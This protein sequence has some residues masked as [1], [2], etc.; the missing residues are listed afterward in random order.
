MSM[1]TPNSFYLGWMFRSCQV[2]ILIQNTKY[3]WG[4]VEN[5]EPVL[6]GY[7]QCATDIYR[8]APVIKYLRS[9][10]YLCF[11]PYVS[12]YLTND[13]K[14]K[15]RYMIYTSKLII[16]LIP[17]AWKYF[18]IIQST[19]WMKNDNKETDFVSMLV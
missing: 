12:Q 15:H 13:H 10:V 16:I 19:D 5:A 9:T 4:Y 18:Y 2:F 6:I 3:I 8:F 1:C 17:K 11:K 7:L 14:A